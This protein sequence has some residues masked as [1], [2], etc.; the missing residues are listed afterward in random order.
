MTVRNEDAIDNNKNVEVMNK[1]LYKCGSC[2][3]YATCP[4]VF[5]RFFFSG[6]LMRFF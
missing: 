1:N 2:K 3:R 5:I 6:L 4:N